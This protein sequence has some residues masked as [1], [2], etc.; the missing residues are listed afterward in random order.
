MRL[1]LATLAA[2]V[3]ACLAVVAPVSAEDDASDHWTEFRSSVSADVQAIKDLIAYSNQTATTE[4]ELLSRIDGLTNR[5]DA[6]LARYRQ[7][8]PTAGSADAELAVQLYVGAIETYDTALGNY[9]TALLNRNR[10]EASL[11]VDQLNSAQT[12]LNTAIGQLRSTNPGGGGSSSDERQVREWLIGIKPQLD[13]YIAAKKVLVDNYADLFRLYTSVPTG[14]FQHVVV[15]KY[16]VNP[17]AAQ[18]I[19]EQIHQFVEESL[20]KERANSY[21]PYAVLGVS[22]SDDMNVIKEQYFHLAKQYHPDTS[23]QDTAEQFR[24]INEAYTSIL[25]EH[26]VAR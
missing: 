17:Q 20:R 7:P 4:A 23:K 21:D 16:R 9:R 13:L 5:L 25:R 1:L 3:A 26:R 12:T 8:H 15:G 24:V 2:A 18:L 19:Q 10:G 14:E 11:A 22:R 6:S